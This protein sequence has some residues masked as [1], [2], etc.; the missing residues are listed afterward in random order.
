MQMTLFSWFFICFLERLLPLG[1]FSLPLWLLSSL[2]ISFDQ[3][4]FPLWVLSLPLRILCSFLLKQFPFPFW[5]FCAELLNVFPPSNLFWVNLQVLFDPH[6]PVGTEWALPRT[7]RKLGE[8]L[9]PIVNQHRP[10]CLRCS[11]RAFMKR[12]LSRPS[13]AFI[14]RFFTGRSLLFRRILNWTLE[15]KTDNA[16]EPIC[17]YKSIFTSSMQLFFGDWAEPVLLVLLRFLGTSLEELTFRKKK[18][19]T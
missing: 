3:C 4:F 6:C 17:V 13:R 18:S 14:K 5:D 1:I 12:F 19:S 16:H 7:F 9:L 8:Q 10:V 11:S 2:L 15:L